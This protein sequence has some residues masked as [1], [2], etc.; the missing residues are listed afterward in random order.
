[1]DYGPRRQPGRFGGKSEQRNVGHRRKCSLSISDTRRRRS[2]F[3]TAS[4]SRTIAQQFRHVKRQH[5]RPEPAVLSA[6]STL[7]V[8]FDSAWTPTNSGAIAG[9]LRRSDGT[10]CELGPP[11]SADYREAEA[12]ILKWQADL[13]PA[14]TMVLVDQ[15][16]I[17]TECDGQRPVED[18]VGALVSRRGGG[19][20]PANTSK[21]KMF[22]TEAPVWSF[23]GPQVRWSCG[24]LQ[25][26][27]VLKGSAGPRTV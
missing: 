6:G 10:F 12:I 1:M 24:S 26:S 9:V 7:L 8:G 14:T 15:P 22:G 21:A 23:L 5:S 27:T 13:M 11:H 16:T 19:M 4:P 2:T 20:Q 17:V 18:I 25:E 3:P